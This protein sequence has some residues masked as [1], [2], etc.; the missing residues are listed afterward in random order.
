MED[1]LNVWES[2]R[3][4]QLYILGVDVSDG[5]GLDRS[6]VD[7]FRVGTLTEPD[8]QVAQFVSSRIDPIDLAHVVDTVGRFYHTE[9]TEALA[10]IECNN[11]GLATQ[12]ELQRH[13]GYSNFFVWQYEDARDP[14]G[15]YSRRLGWYTS[16]R[17]RPLI[18]SRFVKGVSTF[19]PHTSLADAR[20]NS[21]ITLEEMRSFQTEGQLW[22][23]EA[24]LG[25]HDDCIMSAAIAVHV[26]Q[27]L[28]FEDR[29]PLSDQRRR[30]SEEATRRKELAEHH[31]DARDYQN[32]DSTLDGLYHYDWDSDAYMG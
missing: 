29:E 2:P 11:H 1:T 23:A 9:G 19:D 6:V 3:H 13:C 18:L 5:I 21:P 10:A 26:A 32:T 22:E 8:E 20:I 12:A 7:A 30:L 14:K 28:H 31:A 4:D 27:T 24:G 15:R 16:V 17:T 25:A